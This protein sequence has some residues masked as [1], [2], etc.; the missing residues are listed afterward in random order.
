MAARLMAAR[1]K[2]GYSL[3]EMLIVL[4]I[5]AIAIALVM[6]RGQAMLD[7][8]TAHAVFFDFQRQMLDLRR[9]AYATQT[10]TAVKSS[11]DTDPADVADRV[12]P[13]RSQWTY[14]LERPINV[15]AGGACTPSAVEVLKAGRTVMHLTMGDNACHFIRQD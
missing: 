3:M 9:E 15:T 2:A 11:D 6:P 8:M 1:L 12:I 5:M 13:L 7:G 4:A 10:P 14:R